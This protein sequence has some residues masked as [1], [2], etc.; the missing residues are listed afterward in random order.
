MANHSSIET[1]RAKL[2][3]SLPGKSSHMKM[4]SLGMN[5]RYYEPSDNYKSAAVLLLL[6]HVDNDINIIY[7]KRPSGNQNDKH[8]GQISF[9]GG[10]LEKDDVSLEACAVRETHEELGLDPA[11][12]N[13]L[14]SLSPLYIYVSNFMVQPFVG[15]YHD[16]PKYA[17][18][19]SEVESTIEFPLK[20]LYK[21]DIIKDTDITI[22]NNT[23]HKVPY[24]DLYGEVLWGATA[25]ITNEF[26]TIMDSSL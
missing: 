15:Y 2:T 11:K 21:S 17:L 7:M 12:I 6:F 26:R 1:I 13:V 20:G 3:E 8:S 14:G 16:K 25:M 23:L 24:F 5:H 18:Q 10:Q 4:A 19:K 22:R 9:P